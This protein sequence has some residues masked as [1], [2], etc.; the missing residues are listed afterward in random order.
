MPQIN[1]GKSPA[2][3]SGE[4]VTASGLNGMI[5]AATINPSVITDQDPF[6]TLTGNEY[7]LI[8]DPASGQLKKTQLKNTLLTG[9]DIK[10]NLISQITGSSAILTIESNPSVA[11]LLRGTGGLS[12]LTETGNMTINTI[13]SGGT[14]AIGV[15]SNGMTF[16]GQGS[17]GNGVINFQTRTIFSNTGAVKLPVGT[18][19][20]RPAVPVAGDL[21]FNTTI[22]DT[23]FY[24]GSAWESSNPVSA[25]SLSTNGYIKLANGFTIQWGTFLANGSNTVGSPQIIALPV[26]FTTAIVYAGTSVDGANSSGDERGHLDWSIVG[27]TTTSQLGIYTNYIGTCKFWA[28]GY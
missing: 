9:E 27:K 17:S 28:I 19:A 25:V 12:L 13:A 16:D 11:M 21:R 14:G 5:D 4:I 22:T 10:T 8:V 24:N 15:E 2:W 7:A 1:N 6:P 23:E 18:T 20:Q 26:T 3:V